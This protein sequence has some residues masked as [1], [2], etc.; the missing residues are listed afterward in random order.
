MEWPCKF[1]DEL[2]KLSLRTQNRHSEAVQWLRE[3]MK[4]RQEWKEDAME[5]VTTGD[6]RW[7]MKEHERMEAQ[8]E[9]TLRGTAQQVKELVEDQDDTAIFAG[10]LAQAAEQALE[11]SSSEHMAVGWQYEQDGEFQIG[12]HFR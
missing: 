10:G 5:E 3:R 6:I 4:A 11:E 2:R 12:T 1:A 8:R 7:V 9:A